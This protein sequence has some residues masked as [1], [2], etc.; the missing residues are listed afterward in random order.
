MP[1]QHQA[2]LTRPPARPA[3]PSSPGHPAPGPDPGP[4]PPRTAAPADTPQP[5]DP[6]GVPEPPPVAGGHARGAPPPADDGAE[7]PT[8]PTQPQHDAPAVGAEGLQRPPQRTPT[9]APMGEPGGGTIQTSVR[10]ADLTNDTAHGGDEAL[11][12]GQPDAEL[13][14][15]TPDTGCADGPHRPSTADHAGAAPRAHLA[16]HADTGTPGEA[17]PPDIHRKPARGQRPG[18]PQPTR[19]STRTKE[20]RHPTGVTA[21]TTASMPSWSPAGMTPGRSQHRR[22]HASTRSRNA[23]R[24]TIR[25]SRCHNKRTSSA[26]TTPW[27]RLPLRA[28]GRGPRAARRT[29]LRTSA[30]PRVRARAWKRP[31]TP[32]VSLSPHRRGPP[33][34]G[35]GDTWTMHAW[36]VTPATP[37]NKQSKKRP[38]T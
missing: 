11:A 17:L 33:R 5:A 15:P 9:P 18:K 34:P 38:K 4:D 31:P 21:T 6:G 10:S 20:E 8:P 12:D 35:G 37:A 32:R 24:R 26:T 29:G 14:G 23:T 1:Q 25:P 36:R 19:P 22:C 16:A 28:R 30:T 13:E 27:G 7:P 3:E 2:P